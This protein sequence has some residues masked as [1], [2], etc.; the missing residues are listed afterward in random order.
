[1]GANQDDLNEHLG[2]TNEYVGGLAIATICLVFTIFC[3]IVPYMCCLN[4]R[5]RAHRQKELLSGD[6]TVDLTPEDETQQ[7]DDTE[8]GF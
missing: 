7:Q 5:M 4:R 2:S 6:K 8:V 3:C 1:M